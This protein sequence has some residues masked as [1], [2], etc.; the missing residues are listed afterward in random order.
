MLDSSTIIQHNTFKL[1]KNGMNSST[2]CK[3]KEDQ[4]PGQSADG[5]M[6]GRTKTQTTH[7]STLFLDKLIIQSATPLRL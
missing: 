4:M 3:E 5:H 6:L 1:E 2:I 7:S